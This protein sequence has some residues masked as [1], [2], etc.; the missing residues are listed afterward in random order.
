MFDIEKYQNNLSTQWLGHSLL[1]F[2]TLGSTNTYLKKLPPGE[3]AHGQLCLTDHQIQGR[4]QYKRSWQVEDAQNL[5][6]T[7]AFRP[8]SDAGRFHILTLA[9]ARA[10]IAQIKACTGCEAHI[11]WPND[12]L[13]DGKKVAGLLTETVFNGN[14]LDRLLVGIGLNV[15]QESFGS[16]LDLKATSLKQAK[17]Q[18]ID[19]EAFL[20]QFLS[21]IELEYLRWHK[22]DDALL[23]GI[24]KKIIGYGRWIHLRINGQEHPGLFKLLGINQQGQLAVITR[25]GDLK[26]FSYEQIRLIVD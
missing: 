1:Y 6:F 14:E 16:E 10:A 20:S 8:K 23:K 13:I 26:T 5:T 18:L 17:G 21:R 9:C 19:R 15:N 2:E 22:Q 25:E 12:V 4:G 11:K 3:V 24:N 7:L